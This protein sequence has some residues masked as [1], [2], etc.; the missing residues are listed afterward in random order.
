M[1]NLFV[2]WDRKERKAVAICETS[3]D[4]SDT[5]RRFVN[6]KGREG[7]NAVYDILTVTK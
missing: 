1:A 6:K 4:A 2:V 5:A 7:N 3:Q